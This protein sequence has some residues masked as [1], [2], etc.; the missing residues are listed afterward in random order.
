MDAMT[1]TTPTTPLTPTEAA[2]MLN[3]KRSTVYRIVGLEWVEYQGGGVRPIRRITRE[4]V[5]RLLERRKAS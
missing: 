5:Y 3:V 2:Q 4:S 1:D